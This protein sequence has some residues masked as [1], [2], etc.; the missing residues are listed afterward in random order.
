MGLR[1][2]GDESS[3]ELLRSTRTQLNAVF[4]QLSFQ[5]GEEIYWRATGGLNKETF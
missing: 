5:V 3:I 1:D 4:V 2:V